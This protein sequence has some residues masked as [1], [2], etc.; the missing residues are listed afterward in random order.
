MREERG[1]ISGDLLVY[2][3]YT[4]WG[5]VVGNVKVVDGGKF[6]LRGAIYGNVQV[7]PGGRMHIFG[8]ISGSV[9]V[10]R[11]TKVIHSGMIGGDVVN[12]GGRFFTDSE[13]KI[14]GKV[15]TLAGETKAL[16]PK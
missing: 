4:L 1:T 7:D 16:T 6:Y 8:R 10:F 13:G 2:E 12:D 5:T 11:G 15:K 14:M 9:K 3:E